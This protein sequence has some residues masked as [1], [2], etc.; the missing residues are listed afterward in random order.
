MYDKHSN[1]AVI[2]LRLQLFCLL[3]LPGS[4]GEVLLHY[5]VSSVSNCE[6]S[7]LSA[8]VSQVS[9]VKFFAD[10]GNRLEIDLSVGCYGLGVYLENLETGRFVG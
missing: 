10:L 1:F 4:F 6:H 5:V 2:E 8:Y 7:S 3:D 9:P